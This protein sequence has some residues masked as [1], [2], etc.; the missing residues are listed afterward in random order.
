[1]TTTDLSRRSV[2]S[3]TA[4][5]AAGG[6]IGFVF[7]AIRRPR[8]S[9]T[10]AANGYGYGSTTSQNPLVAVA[11]VPSDGGVILAPQHVVVVKA[12]DGTVHAFS[13]TCTHQGCTVAKVANGKI[14][15][16]CHG[17]VFDANTGAVLA[18]PAPA[19]LPKIRV[20]VRDGEVYPA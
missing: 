15:C 2:L 16:P 20:T 11:A 3:G 17:S 5:F 14:T 9:S 1:M 13:S 7:T 8:Q 18:G 10:S 4:I 12:T 19:P 6:L